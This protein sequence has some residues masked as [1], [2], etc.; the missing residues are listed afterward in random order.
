VPAPIFGIFVGSVAQ[1]N[2]VDG[3]DASGTNCGAPPCWPGIRGSALTYAQGGVKDNFN[4][5][6]GDSITLAL[7]TGLRKNGMG[8]NWHYGFDKTVVHQ[9]VGALKISR[10]NGAYNSGLDV[11]RIIYRLFDPATTTWSPWDSSELNPTSVALSGPDTILI[12]SEYRVNWPPA[13]KYYVNEG[14]GDIGLAKDEFLPGNQSIGWT[15]NGNTKYSGVKFLPKGTRMQ[16]YF[17]AVDIGGGISYQFQ[18]DAAGRE[19]EDIPYLPGSA[20]RAPDIIEFD[21]LPRKYAAG[22]AGTLAAGKTDADVLNL[23]GNYSSWNNQFDPVTQALRGMGVRADR[24]RMLQGLGN[25]S[26]VGGH[27]LPG[28]R[29]DRLSNF[30]PNINEYNIV[31][32]LADN[33]RMIIQSSH[34]RSSTIFEEQDAIVVENWW[35]TKTGN[36]DNDGDRCVFGSGDDMFNALLN[37]S[38]S[39]PQRAQQVSLAQNVFGVASVVN[40]WSNPSNRQYPTIDDRFA[41]GGPGLAAPGTYTYPIDGGCPTPNR[42]D[43]LTKVGSADAANAVIYPDGVTEVAGIARM[44]EKDTPTADNDRNKALAYGFSIQF[45]RTAG[46]PTNAANYVRTG[47]ENR[48]RVLYK[49]LTS[50]RRNTAAVTTPCWPCPS[51]PTEISSNWATAL[52]FNTGTYG[53][54]YQIQD[55]TTATGVE[56]VE[57]PKVNRLEGNVPNPFNPETAVRFSAAQPG[58]VTIRVFDVSGRLVNTLSKNVTETGLNEIRWNGKSSDGKPMASGMYFY[59][60]R[61][62]NGEESEAKMTMLK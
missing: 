24:Y 14:A 9:G 31:G 54:L 33:Y 58:K 49:F 47:V 35:N 40:A 22:A 10:M 39:F 52:G 8:I 51:N 30:Y 12:D 60:I 56:L 4:C 42:F 19:V 3:T 48:M 27:E 28:Q 57:A 23:D 1:S 18:S 38:L 5:G 62:A 2:F 16:Y 13:D 50:C 61:F 17:K 6:Y 20:I 34:T 55:Y 11:P 29:L 43:G 45:I 32:L 37:A 46:I 7:A 26:N 44:S 41:G 53:D 15:L 59:K 25:G 36:L 21:I